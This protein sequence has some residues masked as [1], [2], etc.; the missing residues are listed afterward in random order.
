MGEESDKMY[1]KERLDSILKE[2]GKYGYVTV[3]YLVSKLHY[4]NA[5]INRDLNV[6]E[7]RKEIRRTYGGVELVENSSVTLPF[8]Y[9]KMH[10]EK[11]KAAQA[12]AA[13][14]EDGDTVFIDAATTTEYIA[15]FITD[16][17]NLTVITNNLAIVMRLS[18]CDINVICLG[19]K[20]SEPP[21][22]LDG[23]DTVEN[24]AKYRADKMFFATGY[25]SAEGWIG[26]GDMYFML[27]KTMAKNSS[28]VY[29]LADHEKFRN[30]RERR[31][32]MDFSEVDGVICDY[33]FSPSVKAK[34]PHVNFIKV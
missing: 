6:L 21:C 34:F 26:A 4:S 29:Y 14:I 17:K 28:K 1:Q 15:E 3:K 11:V 23:V 20:V 32:L 5:T 8:R 33:E 2:I 19:G 10:A 31:I 7:S 27:Q 9:H 16:R 13:L 25:V 22:M 12:A 24:A 30:R 18:E